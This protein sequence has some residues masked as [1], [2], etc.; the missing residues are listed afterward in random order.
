MFVNFNNDKN[1]ETGGSLIEVLIA[2]ALV[3]ILLHGAATLVTRATSSN[4]DQQL[5]N[6]AITQLRS[7]LLR[8]DLC[9][10]PPTIELPGGVTLTADVQG[11]SPTSVV[12]GGETID[13]VVQPIRLAVDSDLLGGRV[14]VGGT[15][16][17]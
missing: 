8:D 1:K 4:T 3:G 7:S 14:V 13:N 10:T 12:I 16:W 15:W 11:C 9:V 2:T 5:L 6:I 17:E